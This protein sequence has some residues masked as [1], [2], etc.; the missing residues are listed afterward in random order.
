MKDLNLIIHKAAK[1]LKWD[2]DLNWV[3]HAM[4]HGAAQD[5]L[6]GVEDE[7]ERSATLKRVHMHQ[8]TY[9]GTYGVPIEARLAAAAV[10][11][12]AGVSTRGKR[13]RYTN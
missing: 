8:C 13:G 11:K 9:K 7:E 10:C 4:R 6:E 1:A 2:D 3:L 5:Q 12:K